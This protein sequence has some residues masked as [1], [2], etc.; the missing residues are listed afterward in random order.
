MKRD[1][2]IYWTATA[3]VSAGMLFSAWLYLSKNDDLVKAFK[4]LGYPMYFMTILGVA[5]LLGAI[6][7]A[8]PVADRIKEWAYAGFFFTF[9]GAAWT[10][11]VTST[12]ATGAIVFLVLLL[13]SYIFRERILSNAHTA[14]AVP[15][16]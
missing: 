8:V 13:I 3:L 11:L 2:I 4:D 1:K 5:K 9:I 10:H 6:V 7:L 12:P 15:V 16:R 14:N